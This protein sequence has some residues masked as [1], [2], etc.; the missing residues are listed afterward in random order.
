[1]NEKTEAINRKYEA[2]AAIIIYECPQ[3]HESVY[4]ESR[5]IIN[6]KFGAGAPLNESTL[7][8]LV[9][10]IK[11]NTKLEN[12]SIGGVIPE[13]LVFFQRDSVGHIVMI[14]YRPAEKRKLLFSEGLHIPDG[15]TKVPAMLYISKGNSLQV[16]V[17]PNNEKPK[18]ATKLYKP[19]YHNCSENGSVCLGSAKAKFPE[20][21]SYMALME[22]WEQLFWGSKFSH[23]GGNNVKGNLNLIWKD[24]MLNPDQNFNKKHLVATGET[25]KDILR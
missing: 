15:E 21:M 23:N 20:K 19:P 8:A 3:T 4:L 16:F 5:K 22:Y 11:I 9:K 1:M 2:K 7:T 14:W 25:F 12:I 18:D 17:L 6:G 13:S 24:K 10:R